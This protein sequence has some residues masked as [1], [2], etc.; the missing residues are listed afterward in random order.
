MLHDYLRDEQLIKDR[1]NNGT[2]QKY[3]E[4]RKEG[5]KEGRKDKKGRKGGKELCGKKVT[6]KGDEK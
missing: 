2:R 5:R 4:R 6:S 3:K 1:G